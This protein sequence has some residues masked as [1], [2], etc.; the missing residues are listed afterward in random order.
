M[1][2]GEDCGNLMF[3]LENSFIR[4]LF[5]V[6][7]QI[8]C[9]VT[10]IFGIVCAGEHGKWAGSIRF[11]SKL[12][13]SF[14]WLVIG[15]AVLSRLSF[16]HSLSGLVVY[17]IWG[18]LG[19]LPFVFALF[20]A[21]QKDNQSNR[22]DAIWGIITVL[23]FCG[24]LAVVLYYQCVTNGIFVGDKLF[25][26]ESLNAICCFFILPV[27]LFF[28]PVF[29]VSALILGTLREK[30]AGFLKNLGLLAVAPIGFLIF[31]G[32]ALFQLDRINAGQSDSIYSIFAAAAGWVIFMFV[33]YGLMLWR[34]KKENDQMKFYNGISGIW[35]VNFFILALFLLGY[36]C[37]GR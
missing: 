21:Q 1:L 36:I 34:G 14:A 13:I 27:I 17:T 22:Y 15:S 29:S 31:T 19:I 24:A 6:I 16:S 7:I 30:G 33:P 10:T 25:Q 11:L 28:I 12:A 37:R 2:L 18:T 35:A 20:K 8:I 26:E 4:I 3:S 5:A 9:L 23:L 32:T